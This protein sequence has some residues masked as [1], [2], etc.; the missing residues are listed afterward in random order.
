MTVALIERHLFGGTCVNTGCTP[1]KTLVASAYA[2]HLARRAADFGVVVDGAGQRRHG[3]RARPRRRGGRTTSR[4]AS[5]RWLR[6]MPGC[7]VIRGHARFEAPDV[8]RV[9]DDR[10]TRAAHLHQRGRPRRRAA[11]ARH[12]SRAPPRPT[13]PL[14]ALDRLPAHLVVVGGSYVGL[15]FA[16][17]YRRFGAEVTVVETAAAPDRRA[18]TTRCRDAIR[19]ILA[20]R[21][22]PSAPPP[23]ASASRRT[24]RGVA[25]SVDC[26]DGRA[27]GGRLRRPAGGR[28]PP[29]HRRPRPR[30][31]RRG[32]RRPRLHPGRRRAG[33]ERA[34]HL[35]AGRL[36]R[37]RRL[38][39]HGV[40]RLRDRR[41][42][43]AR[44][45]ARA[46]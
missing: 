6:A 3:P 4:A 7:T 22:S 18:R 9:G 43:P 36:Q 23:S 28:P 45:R 35:G 31:R 40:Q 20:A 19:E 30:A 37:P 46:A 39:P 41:R 44:R 34:R 5:K 24:R 12:R 10:L 2:A 33:D 14:L 42:Q 29:E 1:T 27:R 16:Q 38:H 15:E 21:A 11:H 13:A 17:M 26:A 8:I 32:H 25:V